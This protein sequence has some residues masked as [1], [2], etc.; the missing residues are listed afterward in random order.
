ME[1]TSVRRFK[2]ACVLG[3]VA[4]MLTSCGGGQKSPSDFLS[5]ARASTGNYLWQGGSGPVLST[6]VIDDNGALHTPI[7]ANGV[8][9]PASST[10]GSYP[11]FG[12]GPSKHF[13]YAEDTA[14]TAVRVFRII[15]TGVALAEIPESG[16]ATQ[17]NKP[18]NSISVDPKGRF[19][20][21]IESPATIEEFAV[22]DSTG[23]L[24]NGVVRIEDGDL[25]E[26]VITPSGKFLFVNDLTRGRIFA[27]AIGANGSL[28]AVSGSPFA[29]PANM[30]ANFI[31]LDASGN[32]LYVALE[33]GP[34]VASAV[35]GF[36]INSSTGQ[37]TAVPGSPFALTNHPAGIAAAPGGY[38]YVSNGDGQWGGERGGWIDGFR[39]AG[40]GA[41][42]AVPGSPFPLPP[43]AGAPVVDAT[44][45][46]LYVPHHS[47][48]TIY[49]FRLDL[50]S[51]ALAAI[52]GSPFASVPQPTRLAPLQIP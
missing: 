19:L 42:T 37:L 15:G 28:N 4:T 52:P 39:I 32:F 22:D 20:Y 25:R 51:G 16:F 10:N 30:Y 35:A 12:T 24:T 36:A 50:S 43:F 33:G 13:L 45:Q 44:G 34:L 5:V 38:I 18:L 9:S 11:S 2:R 48:S 1:Q 7:S 27:Y 31:T 23:I 41:L 49:G 3:L 6:A 21:L 26:G 46:F 8:E 17:A 47:T 29:V 14:S 40:S